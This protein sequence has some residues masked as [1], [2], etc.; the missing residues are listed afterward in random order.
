MNLR[1]KK[2][3]AAKTFRV[4]K[5]KIVFVKSRLD[6]IKEAITKQDIRD[7]YEEG[8]VLI[9]QAGGRKKVERKKKKIGP[10]NVRKK[11]RRRK[12]KYIILTRKLRR[13]LKEY[14]KTNKISGKQAEEA[15]KKIKNNEFKNKSN[16]N[17]YLKINLLEKGFQKKQSINLLEKSSKKPKSGKK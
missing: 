15:R 5:N 2:A 4:G 8:A 11:I 13:H 16:L 12:R 10:G 6:E 14:V 9:R 17:E 3:L 1:K 7:L